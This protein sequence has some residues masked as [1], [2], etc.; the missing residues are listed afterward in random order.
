MT[1]DGQLKRAL[2][3]LKLPNS[4][5]ESGELLFGAINSTYMTGQS[6][7]LD[8]TGHL[9]DPRQEWISGGWQVQAFSAGFGADM[10]V[11]LSNQTAVFTTI[12]PEVGLPQRLLNQFQPLLD[13]DILFDIH[14]DKR[15][16]LPDFT[17]VLVSGD[18]QFSFVLSPWDYIRHSKTA[19]RGC[20]AIFVDSDEDGDAG[21][22]LVGSFFLDRYY[23][24]FDAEGMTITSEF[25]TT[26]KKPVRL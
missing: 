19:T 5:S 2:F 24:I 4:T 11:D 26:F 12:F 20:R 9:I 14:C 18:R 7:V 17:L 15:F 8:I 21:Y 25:F 1:R 22:I 16:V 6:A 23:N 10:T 3:S 13:G